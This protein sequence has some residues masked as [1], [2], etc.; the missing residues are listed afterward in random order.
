MTIIVS[1]REKQ[2]LNQVLS[3]TESL[4]SELEDNCE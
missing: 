2:L 4:I 3:S 1:S